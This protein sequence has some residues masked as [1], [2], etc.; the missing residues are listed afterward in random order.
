LVAIPGLH[1]H[2][3]SSGTA[4][5]ALEATAAGDG[6]GLADTAADAAAGWIG[7]TL[8]VET[9]EPQ[10]AVST[11]AIASSGMIRRISHIVAPDADSCGRRELSQLDHDH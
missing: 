10:A 6:A 3:A 11:A 4:D 1:S 5:G 7:V 2:T 8:G 9:E